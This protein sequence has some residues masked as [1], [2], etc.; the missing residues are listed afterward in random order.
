MWVLLLFFT[1]QT[2]L[3]WVPALSAQSL[4]DRP[5]RLSVVQV[6]LEEAIRALQRSSGV[7]MAYS[8]DLLPPRHLVT[9]SCDTVSV[10]TALDIILEDTGLYY[11][12]GRRQVFIGLQ[13]E[14]GGDRVPDSRGVSGRVVEA[15]SD[16]PVAGAEVALISARPL[17]ST[18]ASGLE[19]AARPWRTDTRDDGRFQFSRVPVGDYRVR[20]LAP[21]FLQAAPSVRVDSG[22]GAEVNVDLFRVPVPLEALVISPG[23]YGVLEGRTGTMGTRITRREIESI[24]QFGDDA[25]RALQRMPGVASGDISTQLNVRGS[26]GRDLLVRLDGMELIEPYHLRDV[27]GVFGIVDIQSVGEIDLVTGGFGVE[28][29]NRYGGVLDM[30]TRAPPVEGTRTT[31]GMSLSSVSATSQGTF[32]EGRGE[33]LSALRWGFLD[34]VLNITDYGG[35]L[36]PSY[37]DVLGKIGYRLSD[38]H[39]LRV[40]LLLAGDDVDWAESRTGSQLL[41]EWANSYL[42]AGWRARVTPRLR[43]NTLLSVGTIHRNRG[44]EVWQPGGG[45][46]SP[47]LGW[48]SDK[49]D[50]SFHQLRQEWQFDLG[51]GVLLKGGAEF[52]GGKGGYDYGGRT[53]WLDIP[54][55]GEELAHIRDSTQVDLD[56]RGWSGAGWAALRAKVG[57]SLAGEI[58]VRFDHQS[59]TGD[60]DFAPRLSLRWDMGPGLVL[61]GS[62]GRYHQSQRIYELNVPDGD[63]TFSPSEMAEQVAIGLEGRAAGG[64]GWRVEGYSRILESPHP[65]YMNMA[66]QVVPFPEL[67]TDRIR[68]APTRAWGRGLEALL[69]S[70]GSGR[71]SWSGSYALAEA[72]QEVGG[73]WVPR[74]LDQRHT[75]NLHLAYRLGQN[76]QISGAYQYHTGWPVTEQHAEPEMLNGNAPPWSHLVR[77]YFGPLNGE[78]LPDY[79]RLDLRTTRKLEFEKSRLELF[80]DI[81]NVT[82]E[83]N[84]R[85]YLYDLQFHGPNAFTTFRG[86]GDELLPI[87]PTVGFRWVF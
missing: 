23:S 72:E 17:S 5:A 47:M 60:S 78:R 19:V 18:D 6:G 84:L 16:F 7:S 80:L 20:V 82:N 22:E 9:C 13:E 54:P 79:Q 75:V 8:P 45:S 69:S 21:G 35:D 15:G 42:W 85:G 65:E 70:G 58:G 14:N 55:G 56:V 77:L 44:G 11:L 63:L 74:T 71:L 76:W 39:E 27:E 59:H 1:V 3:S 64:L 83:V 32:S 12:E 41:S 81:F 26:T 33:W 2:G 62:W 49:G 53:T 52:W 46:Y 25:F 61:K 51:E 24:P 86:P 43:A 31:L 38:A 34:F 36:S 57:E 67:Q 28:F 50:F 73:I 29:G 4:L 48:V 66:R 30:R 40:N 68:I 37:W 87:L 10:R